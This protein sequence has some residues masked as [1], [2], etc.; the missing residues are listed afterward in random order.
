METVECPYCRED[1]YFEWEGEK[2]FD[3]T[4]EHCEHDFIVQVELEPIFHTYKK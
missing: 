3:I 4:C 1:N 2:E